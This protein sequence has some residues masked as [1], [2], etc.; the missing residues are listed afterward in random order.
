MCTHYILF[1]SKFVDDIDYKQRKDL[2]HVFPCDHRLKTRIAEFGPSMMKKLI[3]W[4]PIYVE[5]GLGMTATPERILMDTNK[6]YNNQDNELYTCIDECMT[7]TGD[8][9]D[10][11][12]LGDIR[13]YSDL[14][15]SKKYKMSDMY[16]KLKDKYSEY[17]IEQHLFRNVYGSVKCA[18]KIMKHKRI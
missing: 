12:T 16:T 14:K 2:K 1:E 3:E 17:Y 5:E 4:F 9:T 10:F 11:V 6:I 13:H 18:K 15:C 7:F 8:K